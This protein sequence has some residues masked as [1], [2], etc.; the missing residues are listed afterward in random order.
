[1]FLLEA[2]A[3]L[4]CPLYM[5]YCSCNINVALIGSA[6]IDNGRLLLQ[7]ILLQIIVQIIIAIETDM[8]SAVHFLTNL[9]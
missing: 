1:M 5:P 9:D 7:E 6:D 3:R 4:S 8:G 2:D